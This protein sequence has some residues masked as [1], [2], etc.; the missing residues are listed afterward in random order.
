M[1]KEIITIA[2][3][4]G[5]G[6]SSTAK[7][8]AE[9]LGYDHFSSG[10][11]FRQIAAEQQQSVLDA[12]VAAEKDSTIDH[13]V[14]QRLRDIGE[15][16]TRKVI[17]SRTAWHWM[18]QAFKVYLELPTRVAAERI[19]AKAHERAEANEDIPESVDEYAKHL[20]D[21][22]KSENKRYKSLYGIDPTQKENYNLV[23]DTSLYPLEEVVNQIEQAY[24]E[25][26]QA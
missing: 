8:L 19:I 26:L 4:L 17:D 20:D 25:W 2:G 13:M 16:D 1:K 22:L 24:T 12:N 10:D 9:R 11:L 14:D 5:S 6:K 7:L 23:V 18:P 3:S 21:R 15:H